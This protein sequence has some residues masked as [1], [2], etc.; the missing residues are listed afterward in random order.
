[1]KR[2]EALKLRGIIENVITN[3]NN[4]DACEAIPLFHNYETDASW[5]DGHLIQTGTR[6]RWGDKLFAARS[7]V[8]AYSTYD[9]TNA[10]SLWEHIEYLHGHRV[11]NGAISASNPV[12]YGEYCW[13]NGVLYESIFNGV[14]V[15][16]PS[17]YP[18]NWREV[19]V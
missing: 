16:R 15:Y 14:N 7:D 13:E 6:I 12:L 11:L 18:A 9:P 1:M 4:A 10:P 19:E 8:W 17:E 2:A 5:W 3:L